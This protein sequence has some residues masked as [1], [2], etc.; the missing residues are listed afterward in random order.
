MNSLA[1]LATINGDLANHTYGNTP[2]NPLT[3]D[4]FRI[5]GCL[6]D[7]QY[8]GYDC[9]L[10]TCPYGDDPNTSGEL[11]EKQTI[12][13][14]DADVEGNIILTF[15]QQVTASISPEATTAEV[16]AALEELP[17]IGTVSVETYEDDGEDQLCT[18]AGNKFA[19]TFLTE[20]DDLPMIQAAT[21]RI[22]TFLIIEEVKGTKENIE[23]SGRGLCDHSTGECQCF[24]G[25]GS[26]NGMGGTGTLRD[27]GYIEPLTVSE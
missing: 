17:N 24:T 9:S 6:C 4:A 27:C 23:C 8:T 18:V 5:F 25:F 10:Y 12:T 20:H 26:S 19:I 11:D 22:D 15:R 3:W 13:C 1:S 2:N 14:I 16:K 7:S 21:Q